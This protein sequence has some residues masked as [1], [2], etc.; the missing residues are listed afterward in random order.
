MDGFDDLLAPSRQILEDNPFADPFAKRSNSPD[1]WATPFA[2]QPSASDGIGDADEATTPTTEAFSIPSDPYGQSSNDPVSPSAELHAES[3]AAGLS[4]PLDL[5]NAALDDDDEEE[6]NKPLGKRSMSPRSPGFRESIPSS[7]SEIATIRPTEPEELPVDNSILPTQPQRSR[8]PPP[9][10]A[11]T[12]VSSTYSAPQP[13]YHS[14][15]F[16]QS[17]SS[18]L[19]SPSPSSTSNS[20]VVSP[21]AQH[22]PVGINNSIS[23][24]TQAGEILGGWQSEQTAWGGA[25]HTPP[26]VVAQSED[27]SDDDKPIGSMLYQGESVGALTWTGTSF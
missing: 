8:T 5:A 22:T 10:G 11:E 2:S 17:G 20:R 19:D 18:R 25:E 12:P 3:P 23:G 16:E 13:Q 15:S 21:L 27:D 9:P 24:L 6:D 26:R 4:D 14:K 1:P 7:F